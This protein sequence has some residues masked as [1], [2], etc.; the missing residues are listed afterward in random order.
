MSMKRVRIDYTIYSPEYDRS[1]G[2]C[3]ENGTMRGARK[4]AQELGVGSLI[5]RNFNRMKPM[6][7]WQSTFC[8]MWDGSAFRKCCSLSTEKWKVDSTNLSQTAVQR[9]FRLR[10][11]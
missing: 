3:W 2:E 11:R 4:K 5:V 1:T 8:W 9:R 10:N 7:W 6:H